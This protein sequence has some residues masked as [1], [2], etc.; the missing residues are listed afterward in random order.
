MLW[1]ICSAWCREHEQK[2]EP[3]RNGKRKKLAPVDEDEEFQAKSSSGSG[4][5]SDVI[6]A[7]KKPR[8]K[9]GKGG[10]RK[11]EAAIARNRE[12]A[13]QRYQ[14]LREA[15]KAAKGEVKRPGKAKTEH[16]PGVEVVSAATLAARSD[17]LAALTVA[18]SPT[19]Q[20]ERTPGGAFT[21]LA[22]GSMSGHVA[23]WKVRQPL[24]Y[25]TG[26]GGTTSVAFL[27]TLL[28][29][30][31]WVSALGWAYREGPVGRRGGDL[32]SVESERGTDSQG[33]LILGT[34][35][36]DGSVRLWSVA[37]GD[38]ANGSAPLGIQPAGQMCAPS[39]EVVSSL[40]LRM[41]G[42]VIK[43]AAAR[44][45]GELLVWQG[46]VPTRGSASQN[47]VAPKVTSARPSGQPLMG[48]GWTAGGEE[49]FTCS[50]EGSLQRWQPDGVNALLPVT[51]EL[52]A[53]DRQ[54]GLSVPTPGLMRGYTGLAV[55]PNGL[56][57]A[58]VR[59]LALGSLDT[60]YQAKAM[61][62]ALQVALCGRG[63][64]K[65]GL[66][67]RPRGKLSATAEAAIQALA[68]GREKA[69]EKRDWLD[70]FLTPTD[71]ENEPGEAGT[72][73]GRE[74]DEEETEA[75]GKA[76]GE[77]SRAEDEG[78][79][80][81]AEKLTREVVQ[82]VERTLGSGGPLV[83]WDV[84]A[85]LRE[86]GADA[87]R[88]VLTVVRRTA[89]GE[90]PGAVLSLGAGQPSAQKEGT[91]LRK[92]E[93]SARGKGSKHRDSV[94]EG[95]GAGVLQTELQKGDLGD[96]EDVAGAERG[97]SEGQAGEAAVRLLEGS[98]ASFEGTVVEVHAPEAEGPATRALQ[99][100]H[101]LLL[102]LGAS[103]D[104]KNGDGD[105][106]LR[107]EL[108][109]GTG[110]ANRVEPSTA[111]G[112]VSSTGLLN[113]RRESHPTARDSVDKEGKAE[114]RQVETELRMRLA[115]SLLSRLKESSGPA[116][117]PAATSALLWADWARAKGAPAGPPLQKLAEDLYELCGT[118]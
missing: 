82:S 118:G 67:K 95:V 102:K 35:S 112:N 31:S 21:V 14:K 51:L 61:R 1:L 52:T 34:G 30:D 19:C 87:L 107:S 43:V 98:A 116:T 7:T 50:Q 55:S 8:K 83:L 85:A 68:A 54:F 78:R 60:M 111:R 53:G 72:G 77:G 25:G 81:A 110:P 11:S 32:K 3:S 80:N 75:K 58:G 17:L 101:V 100:L 65:P 64:V 24:R 47:D 12:N 20:H 92:D 115:K 49:V 70:E 89:R 62:G 28:A 97:L 86:L 36:S 63:G 56:A 16:A 27:G 99:V 46:P 4:S 109:G 9:G 15:N 45:A 74:G 13:R 6:L 105:R 71:G 48:L 113:Q 37:T 104:S 41:N 117:G 18:W 114:M 33:L 103:L 76:V 66:G 29:H 26:D 42:D 84:L 90:G 91:G 40:S 73:K 94:R 39:G 5:D 2:A 79:Q 10:K 93:E 22:V 59:T 38:S 108:P 44:G 69:P 57:I 96:G 88:Q 106:A 23:L